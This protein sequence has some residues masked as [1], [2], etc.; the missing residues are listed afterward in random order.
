MS[1]TSVSELTEEAE[2]QITLFN[3]FSKKVTH[4]EVQFF[5]LKTEYEKYIKNLEKQLKE[6]DAAY[7]ALNVTDK[8]IYTF[9]FCFFSKKPL[10]EFIN[11]FQKNINEVERIK[12]NFRNVYSINFEDMYTNLTLENCGFK[13]D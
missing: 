11:D 12:N 13:G 6:V 5:S 1:S 4:N 2:Y 3:C 7:N 9:D 10:S 8:I